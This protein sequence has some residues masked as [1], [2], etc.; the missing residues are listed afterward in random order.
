MS[1]TS[2]V[3]GASVYEAGDQRNVKKSE[4]KDADRYNEGQPHSHKP[5]DSSKLRPC[6]GALAAESSRSNDSLQRTSEASPTGWHE[7]KR[8]GQ[9]RRASALN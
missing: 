6:L 1:G 4:L 7:R 8:H 9:P 2:N 3:G 5:N